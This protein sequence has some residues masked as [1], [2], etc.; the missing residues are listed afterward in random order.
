VRLVAL[1]I[2]L[3]MGLFVASVIECANEGPYT[4]WFNHHHRD[5]LLRHGLVGQS[6]SE[7]ERILGRPTRITDDGR[8]RRFTYAPYPWL[9]F[10]M[11]QVESENGIVRRYEL[12]DD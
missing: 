12:F 2:L 10:A 7:L 5:L 8:S 3:M 4:A 9:P 6:D 11:F 1:S